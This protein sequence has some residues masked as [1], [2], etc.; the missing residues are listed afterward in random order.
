MT[1]T[2]TTTTAATP[3]VSAHATC[4][5]PKTKAARAACRRARRA[6]WVTVVRGDE[7]AAKGNTLRVFVKGDEP[8]M[9]EGVMLGWGDKT[10]IVRVNDDRVTLKVDDIDRVEARPLEG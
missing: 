4:D 8:D 7:L 1:D 5:H 9:L 2:D 6:E 10:L 3:R